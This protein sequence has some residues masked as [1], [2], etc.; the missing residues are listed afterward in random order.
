MDFRWEREWRYGSAKGI[1]ELKA[2][3][4]FVGLCPDSYIDDFQSLWPEIEFIDPRKP[5]TWYAAKLIRARQRLKMKHSV[6]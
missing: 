2:E 5:K 6:V 1:Y 3:E 4:V